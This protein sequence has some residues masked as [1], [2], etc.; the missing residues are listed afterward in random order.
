M[1]LSALADL[2][3][4]DVVSDYSQSNTDGTDIT[5]SSISIDDGYGLLCFVGL[6]SDDA[7]PDLTVT[8]Q[9]ADTV[10][11]TFTRVGLVFDET[12]DLSIVVFK[13]DNKSIESYDSG[14]DKVNRVKVN[15]DESANDMSVWVGVIREQMQVDMIRNLESAVVGTA[16][17]D[18]GVNDVFCLEPYARV[19]CGTRWTDSQLGTPDFQKGTGMEY[20]HHEWSDGTSEGF[21]V[22]S[23][24]P[25]IPIQGGDGDIDMTCY[26]GGGVPAKSVNVAVV[27]RS[28]EFID[29]T[30][31]DPDSSLSTTGP[32][33][34][35]YWLEALQRSDK[36]ITSGE[37]DASPTYVT[38]GRDDVPGWGD[39]ITRDRAIWIREEFANGQPP[40]R[41][42]EAYNIQ[43]MDFS[44][45]AA[46]RETLFANYIATVKVALEG[47]DG[48]EE[49]YEDIFDG[50]PFGTPDNWTE[51]TGVCIWDLEEYFMN[52]QGADAGH[53]AYDPG[54]A[55]DAEWEYDAACRYY[56]ERTHQWFMEEFCKG[57]EA[58]IY[59]QHP[60]SP[61][62]AE[63]DEPD[64]W[65]GQPEDED[66][67]WLFRLQGSFD[68]H[69]YPPQ[70]LGYHD[71]ETGN[72]GRLRAWVQNVL[73][74]GQSITDESGDPAY[75]LH[76]FV[77]MWHSRPNGNTWWGPDGLNETFDEI[78]DIREAA[79]P[80]IGFDAI[81]QGVIGPGGN[82]GVDGRM[83]Y[84]VEEYIDTD[85]SNFDIVRIVEGGA[86]G[87]A[88][89]MRYQFD[90]RF[91]EFK[92]TGS[93]NN[94]NGGNVW[95][96][97]YATNGWPD[98]YQ[99][100]G[101]GLYYS[102]LEPE[103]GQEVTEG[104][105]DGSVIRRAWLWSDWQA[106]WGTDDTT[107]DSVLDELDNVLGD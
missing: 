75:G 49:R 40:F 26:T 2:A 20:Q 25:A 8:A 59:Y 67:E 101:T 1:S 22:F 64:E 79:T 71:N 4:V 11:A 58:L 12:L 69:L 63:A 29:S 42:G 86:M 76:A 98:N 50:T 37:W 48:S 99:D 17:H 53:M 6:S 34:K 5:I 15:G 45:V 78:Q 14:F 36:V 74:Y 80:W 41:L 47:S 84:S 89:T 103:N 51:W 38:R 60:W 28:D 91:G 107:T 19:I 54:T 85:P 61:L 56:W 31:G 68:L 100:T 55:G 16:G 32:S 10:R 52:Y 18:H 9:T 57:A 13:C 33:G 96:W 66:L 46:D 88:G 87:A 95:T 21:F 27:L 77:T 102:N 30:F 72:A 92:I 39:D 62:P 23:D 82:A 93:T 65:E 43:M 104:A 83:A 105:N 94:D 24:H 3:D 35:Q 90:P 106:F 81:F 70:S 7:D 44:P 73:E 97:S